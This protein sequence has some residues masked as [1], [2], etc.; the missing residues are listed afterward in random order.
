MRVIYLPICLVVF[1]VMSVVV[2]VLILVVVVLL[3]PSTTITTTTATT[4][5]ALTI[6]PSFI[7]SFPTQQ[8]LNY[9]TPGDSG[10]GI[11]WVVMVVAVMVGYLWL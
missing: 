10:G 6:I 2:E 9:D 7:T 3:L 5:T 4:N 1:L 8:T 11:G